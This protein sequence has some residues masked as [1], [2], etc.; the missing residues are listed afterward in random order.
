MAKKFKNK[1]YN[2][3]IMRLS[4]LMFTVGIIFVVSGYVQDNDP[5]CKPKK[6]I[7]ILPRDVYDQLIMDSTLKL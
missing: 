4:L 7:R 3:L 6:E 1:I 2:Y 5:K